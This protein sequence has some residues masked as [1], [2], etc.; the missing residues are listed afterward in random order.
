MLQ[1]QSG[2]LNDPYD[3]APEERNPYDSSSE[4]L[5]NNPVDPHYDNPPP[6][7]TPAGQ[8]CSGGVGARKVVCLCVAHRV[9]LV[10]SC[11]CPPH[12]RTVNFFLLAKF[13]TFE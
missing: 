1:E 12:P 8:V 2:G 10:G 9:F 11:A 3:P 13:P 7:P 6:P 4:S 5:D